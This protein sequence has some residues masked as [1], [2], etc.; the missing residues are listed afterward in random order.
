MQKPEIKPKQIIGNAFRMF[1][2]GI[3]VVLSGALVAD[4]SH[5]GGDP[6]QHTNPLDII[7]QCTAPHCWS[8]ADWVA[9]ADR[10]ECKVVE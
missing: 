6:S 3:V 10:L 1:L 5:C 9:I 7:D 4:L 8:D 2:A